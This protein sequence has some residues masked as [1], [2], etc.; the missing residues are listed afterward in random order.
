MVQTLS[1]LAQNTDS[2]WTVWDNKSLPDSVRIEALCEMSEILLETQPDIANALADTII[3]ISNSRELIKHYAHALRIKGEYFHH[4]YNYDTALR[5]YNSSLKILKEYDLKPDMIILY[6]TI[7]DNFFHQ[8][9]YPKADV[10]YEKY[11]N[12]N[13]RIKD[14]LGIANAYQN[15]GINYYF[16]GDYIKSLDYFLKAIDFYRDYR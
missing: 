15:I 2:L 7:G 3:N 1:G 12:E 11:L 16:Q 13:V 6:E 10:Y 4:I 8:H 5:F 14:T 9:D